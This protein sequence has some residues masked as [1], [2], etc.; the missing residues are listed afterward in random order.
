MHAPWLRRSSGTLTTRV[1][2]GGNCLVQL[3]QFLVYA[4]QFETLTEM[5]EGVG[6]MYAIWTSDRLEAKS[7]ERDGG[8]ALSGADQR[9]FTLLQRER[10]LSGAAGP[11]LG[12][13]T[14]VVYA[15]ICT[16]VVYA[17]I[18][19][20]VIYACICTA[21]VYAQQWYMHNRNTEKVEVSPYPGVCPCVSVA[22][23]FAAH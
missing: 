16:A 23:S 14:A 2:V 19:T 1:K 13:C 18:C 17:C 10:A 12:I 8:G 21:V 3:G 22:C 20:A 15:C 11:V 5:K 9:V 4:Q 6:W 7:E